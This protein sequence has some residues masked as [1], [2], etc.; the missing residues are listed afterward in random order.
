[1]TQP[2]PLPDQV[3]SIE[4]DA[5]IDTVWREITKTG[6]IQRP[7]NN[8]VLDSAM[9]PGAR[10]RYYSPSRKRVFVVGEIVELVPP[11]RFSHTW[12]FTMHAEDFTLV[13]WELAELPGGA[14][15]VTLTHSR[16]NESMKSYRNVGATW[17]NILRLLKRELET[18]DID[19]KAKLMY[20]MLGALEFMLP[21]TTSVAYVEQQGW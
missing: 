3:L 7:L 5:P 12:K 2:K 6:A 16:W 4:I 10:L 9:T 17:G 14:C 18:G 19:M 8:T 15:R 13:T 1:M 21:K 20:G 11:R